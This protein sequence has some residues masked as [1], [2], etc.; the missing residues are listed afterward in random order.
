[1]QVRVKKSSKKTNKVPSWMGGRLSLS[2]QMSE[3]LREELYTARLNKSQQS[4]EIRSLSHLF[5]RQRKESI[6]PSPDELLIESFK[7]RDGYHHMVYPFEGRFVHEAMGSLLGYRISLL[8]P[9]T[10]SLA[11][12]DYGFELLSDQEIDIQQLLDNNLFPKWPAESSGILRLSAA[13]SLPATPT[14]ALK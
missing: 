7:T 1:M 14:K 3:L 8:S 4:V 10:F 5:Q 2:A 9:I 6:V 11:F 13:W 12:N